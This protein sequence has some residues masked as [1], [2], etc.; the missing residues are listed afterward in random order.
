MIA[1]SVNDPAVQRQQGQSLARRK[2]SPWFRRKTSPACRF[3][4]KAGRAPCRSNVAFDGVHEVGHVARPGLVPVCSPMPHKER[5]RVINPSCA[6]ERTIVD[7]AV[8]AAHHRRRHQ[9]G[10]IAIAGV[11]VYAHVAV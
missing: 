4:P 11:R 6:I 5:R 9:L 1:T 8:H 7:E 2:T 3:A 10:Q